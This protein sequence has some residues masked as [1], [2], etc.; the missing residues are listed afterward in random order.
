MNI[1]TA[2]QISPDAEVLLAHVLKKNKAWIFANPE[3]RLAP[4][5]AV[6]YR[7]LIKKRRRGIPAAYLLGRKEFFGLDLKVTP[8]VLIP[9]PETELLV[10]L[11]LKLMT[12]NYSLLTTILDIGTGSG[13]IIVSIAKKLSVILEARQRRDDR[14][15][16]YRSLRSLQDDKI[17][18]LYATDISRKALQIARAN[19]RRHAVANNIKFFHGNLLDPFFGHWSL[20]IGHS[21]IIANL[22][23]LTSNQVRANP[24]LRHE[25]LNALV[26][27]NDGLKYYRKLFK[28]I[29]VIARSQQTTKPARTTQSG[30]QSRGN[31]RLPRP[32]YG[33]RN[34]IT[35]LLEHDPSQVK[36]LKK[37]AKALLPGKPKITF[38]RDLSGRFRVMEICIFK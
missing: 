28:Q 29:S 16:S 34:D 26:G 11:A 23:Y 17:I 32:D 20:G 4:A 35:L 12:T 5:Q 38:H 31:M 7:K 22:P 2:L 25:P 10:E 18:N 13:N 8:D 19:A 33:S 1:Q 15:R 37:L 9:R 24:D 3:H 27:G 6:K 14:I 21:I 36:K 30:R